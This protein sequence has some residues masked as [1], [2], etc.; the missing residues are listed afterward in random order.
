MQFWL[1]LSTSL[2]A[3]YGGTVV[4]LSAALMHLWHSSFTELATGRVL[5]ALAMLTL[6][7]L[8]LLLLNIWRPTKLLLAVRLC[9]HLGVW[10]FCWTLL[11]GVFALP[12]HF[13]ALAPL[14][15]Q[16]FI[17]GW[18]LLA[19]ASWRQTSWHRE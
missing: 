10:L 9:W 1:K 14:G 12:L 4:A 16:S 18:L 2:A 7:S 3:L 17:L 8:G 5:A 19:I 11:S 6:H 13:S 15:G